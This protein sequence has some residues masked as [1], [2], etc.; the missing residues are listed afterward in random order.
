MPAAPVNYGIPIVTWTDVT[1]KRQHAHVDR[2]QAGGEHG[3]T[4]L[5][6]L[7]FLDMAN[8]HAQPLERE[9]VH[10]VLI[11]SRCNASAYNDLASLL[12]AEHGA[13]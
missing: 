12:L 4:K 10:G 9:S 2:M 5:E 1:R 7:D 13:R 8:V 11:R 6:T 3:M